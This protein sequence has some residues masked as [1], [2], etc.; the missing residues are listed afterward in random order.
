M[1]P[2]TLAEI[3]P[4]LM[5]RPPARVLRFIS[6]NAC[7]VARNAPVRL[8]STTA[9]QVSTDRSSI[10]RRRRRPPGVVEEQ[11]EPPEPLADV[12][13]SAST[14]AGSLTSAGRR[15]PAPLPA[16]AAVAA[17]GSRRRPAS[18]TENPA[19]ASATVDARPMPIRPR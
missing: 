16:A 17:S 4:L 15:G 12:P 14:G 10:G 13:N 7:C 6:R 5:I 11:V 9:R 3:D 8:M 1:R 19:A 2:R 18:A